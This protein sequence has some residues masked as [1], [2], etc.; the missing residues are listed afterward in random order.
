MVGGT[1]EIFCSCNGWFCLRR[2]FSPTRA[3]APPPLPPPPTLF[4]L[5]RNKSVAGHNFVFLVLIVCGGLYVVAV[6]GFVIF[7]FNC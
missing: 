6:V 5:P 7:V 2:R 1:F 3:A 4:H